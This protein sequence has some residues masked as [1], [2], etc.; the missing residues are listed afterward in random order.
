[1]RIAS[2]IVISAYAL[3]GIAWAIALF[4]RLVVHGGDLGTAMIFVTAFGCSQIVLAILFLIS[5]VVAGVSLC[6]TPVARSLRS[7]FVLAFALISCLVS[8][9]YCYFFFY[10]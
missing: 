9:W 8:C 5:A 2:R 3:A 7:F 6:R 10:G 1:M 4:P